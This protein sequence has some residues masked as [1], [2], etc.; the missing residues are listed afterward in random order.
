LSAAGEATGR[1]ASNT[2]PAD[3][4]RQITI[5]NSINDPLLED[6]FTMAPGG[7]ADSDISAP[8]R[9]A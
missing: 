3:A 6:P 4:A 8:A 7:N 2:A 5:A 9:M 1:H